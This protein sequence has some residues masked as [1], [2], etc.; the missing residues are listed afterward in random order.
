MSSLEFTEG[1]QYCNGNKITE[2]PGNKSLAF[3]VVIRFDLPT[4]FFKPDINQFNSI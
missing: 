4:S 1:F 3:N 2:I